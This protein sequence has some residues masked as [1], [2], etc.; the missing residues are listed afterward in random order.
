MKI[1]I[2]G[3]GNA[4]C[5]TALHYAWHT[6]KDKSIEVELRYNP[7]IPT[8]KVGQATVQ[9]PPKLLWAA[10]G[11]NWYNNPIH[12]TFK[13]GILYE[14]WGKNMKTGFILFPQIKWQCTIVL[15]RCKIMF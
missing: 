6:R 10:T 4:G 8:E 11:F 15:K 7:N 12:A 2:V 5:L 1:V 9:E 14:N 3:A 13:T